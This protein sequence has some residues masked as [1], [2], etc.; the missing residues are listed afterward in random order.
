M[1]TGTKQRIIHAR[2]D[3]DTHDDLKTAGLLSRCSQSRVAREAIRFYL[4]ALKQTP[5]WQ[6]IKTFPKM[7]LPTASD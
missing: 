6:N 3:A 1:E 2:I 7:D 4:Q 5:Q